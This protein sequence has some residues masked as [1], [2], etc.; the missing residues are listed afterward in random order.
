MKG[1]E[2]KLRAGFSGHLVSLVRAMIEKNAQEFSSLRR[3]RAGGIRAADAR[4]GKRS[5]NGIGRVVVEFEEFLGSALPV[6]DIGFIP[7]FPQPGFYF[8]VAIA[9]AKMLNKLKND[10]RPLLIVLRRVGP[11]GKN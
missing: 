4:F 7:D 11:A 5:Q 1:D 2:I 9:L 6:S 10:F 3:S 8:R